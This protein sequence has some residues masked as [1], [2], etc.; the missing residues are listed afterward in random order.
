M[1]KVSLFKYVYHNR[2]SAN[3]GALILKLLR[4]SYKYKMRDI[5]DIFMIEYNDIIPYFDDL[6]N[7]MTIEKLDKLCT[8]MTEHEPKDILDM[9]LKTEN[10]YGMLDNMTKKL[11]KVKKIKEVYQDNNREVE[12]EEMLN[13]IVYADTYDEKMNAITSAYNKLNNISFNF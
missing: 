4:N 2:K 8:M 10:T 3:N 11:S 12:L 7:R 13:K 5:A 9:I 1:P 6:Y